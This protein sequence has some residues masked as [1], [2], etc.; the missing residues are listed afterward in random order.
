MTPGMIRLLRQLQMREK[1]CECS[2]AL[3]MGW[4]CMQAG[5]VYELHGRWHGDE[6]NQCYGADCYRS[7]LIIDLLHTLG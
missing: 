2:E 1:G 4:G 5:G 7:A 6:G 3:Y